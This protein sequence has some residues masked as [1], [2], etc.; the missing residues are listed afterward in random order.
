MRH[1]PTAATGRTF[2]ADEPILD[3][4]VVADALRGQLPVRAEVLSSPKL[5][6]RQ[7]A[8][9][10]GYAPAIEPRLSECD[11]GSWEGLAYASIDPALHRQWLADPDAAPHGGESLRDFI[12]RISAWLEE[13]AATA[14]R[15]LVAF[16]HAGVIR[17]AIVHALGASPAALW[18]LTVAPLSIVA[19]DRHAGGWSVTL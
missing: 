3:K 10:A 5:R 15:P 11:F 16:T 18:R 1:A 4:S 14:P 9:A 8:E 7:T 12:G 19:L 13:I 6:C 17:V 2:A